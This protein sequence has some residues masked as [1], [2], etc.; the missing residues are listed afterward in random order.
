MA[1]RTKAG[2]NERTLPKYAGTY[3][4]SPKRPESKTE[5]AILLFEISY[6]RP[7]DGKRY[8][9]RCVFYRDGERFGRRASF[10]ANPHFGAADEFVERQLAEVLPL[11]PGLGLRE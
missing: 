3:V 8:Q 5:I 1:L 11:R 9:K 2:A 7:T 6:L 4:P 10:Q